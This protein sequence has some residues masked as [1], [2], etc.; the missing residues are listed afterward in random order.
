MDAQAGSNHLGW[1]MDVFETARQGLVLW[2]L[3]EDGSRYRF[4]QPFPITFY[5]AAPNARL[6]ELRRQLSQQPIKLRLLETQR[7]DLFVNAD[8]PVLGITV[9]QATLQP[10]LF[11]RLSH[12]FPDITFYDADVQ[13]SLR[14]QAQTGVHPLAYCRVSVDEE[15]VIQSIQALD[16]PWEL[17]PPPPPLRIL[18]LE[19]DVNPAHSDPTELLIRYE[20]RTGRIPLQPERPFIINIASILQ[21]YDP[22]ILLTNWGDTWMI[23][24]LMKLSKKWK[25][26]LPL[27]R[28][29]ARGVARRG[30]KVYFSYGQVIHRGQQIHLFGRL[31]IDRCNA[32][33]W[34]DY[35]LDGVFELGRITG[36]PLQMSARVS[37][38]SGISAM[39][40]TTALHM[41]VLI[42]WHKQ[43]A[44][45]PRSA[46]NL[47][48]GDQGGLVYQPTIGLH[49]HVGEIDFVSMYPSVMVHFNISPETVGSRS[50]N[51]E[52]IP[53]L[54]MTIDRTTPGLVPLTLQPLLKKR[55]AFKEQILTLPEWD[56]RKRRYKMC[57]LAHKWLLVTCF[58]YLGYKN[59]RFG[60]IEAHQAVTAYGRETLLAAKDAAEGQGFEVLHMYVDGL[61]VR[62]PGLKTVQDFQP[63]LDEV[64][65]KTGLP[66][67]LDGVFRWVAF[68]PSRRDVRIPV[69]NRYFG[70]FQDGTIKVRGIEARRG[71]T[72]AC[73]SGMQMETLK[74]MAKAASAE[75][76][77]ALLPQ[78]RALLLKRLSLIYRRMLPMEEYLVSLKL[79]RTLEE[80]K[81]PNTP[82]AAALAQLEAVGKSLRPGQR[83]RFLLTLG[84]PGVHAWDLPEKLDTQRLDVERYKVLFL[85]AA[86]TLMQPLG[87][88]ETGLEDWLFEREHPLELPFVSF[89]RV[90]Q[91]LLPAFGFP[92]IG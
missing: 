88:S 16:T 61:W 30:E 68:L 9:E 41:G 69:P 65:E 66:I 39:Q 71:D 90:G 79:S 22:D 75:E 84:N 70:V 25:V 5:A 26:P 55:I 81:A 63:I 78:I 73:I 10:L 14:Y 45:D 74:L 54:G 46:L 31:H 37:P 19:P 4:T 8:I 1:V 13:L 80:Y 23:D 89:N 57:S 21:T 49:S 33:L 28:E 86:F 32:M 52:L 44:E 2:F 87:F 3:S 48:Y 29:P 27:N 47:F 60:R 83:M 82:T 53:E 36:L 42:P 43:Q 11:Q 62:K 58:G 17:D 38:G 76:L 15:N 35:G 92:E 50:P 67:S 51:A 18:S 91:H 12:D 64:A 7:R 85:R 34:G 20:K 72:P 6:Q 77:P 24:H 56:P 40:M 59:A